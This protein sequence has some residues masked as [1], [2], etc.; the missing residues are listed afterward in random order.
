VIKPSVEVQGAPRHQLHRP[1]HTSATLISTP[2]RHP[3]SF[4]EP[5]RYPSRVE[6]PA[7]MRHRRCCSHRLMPPLVLLLLIFFSAGQPAAATVA[8]R[9][10]KAVVQRTMAQREAKEEFVAAFVQQQR[11]AAVRGRLSPTAARGRERGAGG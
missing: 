6:P 9:A 10:A 7:A 8:S 11:D 5:R 4:K 1:A 2:A 3:P